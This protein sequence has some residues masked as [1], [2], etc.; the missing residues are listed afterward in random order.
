MMP[1]TVPE[2]PY[3]LFYLKYS[4]YICGMENIVIILVISALV[5]AG[6]ALRKPSKK[7][8]QGLIDELDNELNQDQSG[9]NK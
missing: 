2:S 9:P 5:I 4:L 3:P 1:E 7:N 8:K 6:I